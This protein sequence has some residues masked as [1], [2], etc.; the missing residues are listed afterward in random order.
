VP[1]W[2]A[3]ASLHPNHHSLARER[4]RLPFADR[5]RPVKVARHER[6]KSGLDGSGANGT[7]MSR[8]QSAQRAGTNG[9]RPPGA[10]LFGDR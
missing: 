3:K 1:V 5:Q 10:G 6:Q 8:P 9:W 4:W 2:A 7:R